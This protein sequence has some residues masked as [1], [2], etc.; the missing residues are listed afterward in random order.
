MLRQ[1]TTSATAAA[2]LAVVVGFSQSSWAQAQGEAVGMFGTGPAR[3]CNTLID[4]R[5]QSVL[6]SGGTFTDQSAPKSQAVLTTH[7]YDCPEPVVAQVEPAAPPPLPNQGVVYFAFDKATLTPEAET[8]LN[9]IV[10]DI[11]GRELG[12][13]TVGGHTDTAGPPEYNMQLSQRRA[14]A[15]AG[16]LTKE[17]IPAQIITTEAFGETQLAVPTP[18]DTPNQANRRATIDFQR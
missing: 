5:S 8:T 16:Q 3:L 1:V 9:D 15:V 11:K 17:G 14:N 6:R 2:V 4:S 12:G 7:T 10:A 13:I 18:P